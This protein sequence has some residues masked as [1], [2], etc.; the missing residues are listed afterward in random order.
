MIA[1]DWQQYEPTKS[2]LAGKNILV[3]GAAD[4]IG[5]A[6]TIA[7]AK[8]GATVLM[9]DKKA[10]HLEKLYDQIIERG[11]TEPVILPVDLMDINPESAT[12]LAQSIHNDIG[13]LDG[14]LHNAADLGSPS[15]LDQYEIKYWDSVMQTNL[16]APYFLTRALLPLLKH[17]STTNILFTSA[18]VGRDAAAYW[19]AYA[20]AYAGLE[21]QMKIWA[22]ELENTSNIK[23]NSIDPGAVRT[24]FRRRSHPG[25]SQEKL[26]APQSIVNAYLFVFASS[27]K[28]HGEQLTVGV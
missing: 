4:G 26:P 15:P 23:I 6:V 21:S 17:E 2:C 16:H 14:I 27:H 19:G 1:F 18:N 3:T 11:A 25:E 5:K 9:L 10:R 8:H 22:E 13:K 12:I 7:L 20:I 28:L 24:S